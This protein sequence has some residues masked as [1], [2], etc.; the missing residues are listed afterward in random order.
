MKTSVTFLICSGIAGVLL[1]IG[2]LQAAAANTGNADRNIKK[3]MIKQE[4][5]NMAEPINR[6]KTCTPESLGISS[7]AL[8]KLI[9]AWNTYEH[10]H[11]FIIK[12]NGRTAAE[13]F[14][15]PYDL[16][17]PHMLFSLS[18]SFISCAVGFAIEEKRFS[19]DTLIL[20]IFPEYKKAVTDERFNRMTIRHLL[21][22]STGHNN[23]A[24]RYFNRQTDP[25]DFK[26]DFFASPLRFEP[27]T[28]FVYNSAATYIL[29]AAVRKVT[30]E[31]P[32]V[33]LRKRLLDPLG[34]GER[35]W[36]KSPDGTDCGGWGY[37]LTTR[38]ISSFAEMLRNGGRI[39]GRQVIPADYFASAVSKLAD[40]SKNDAPDWK[41]G[42]GF[43][44]WRTRHNAFRADGSFGQYAIVM[45]D[46]DMTIAITSG[47]S[48]MPGI[49]D[50]L[51]DNLLPGV[52]DK[53]LPENPQAYAELQQKIAK[54][55]LPVLK[56][57]APESTH[58]ITASF[59]GAPGGITGLEITVS[60]ENCRLD[61]RRKDRPQ[62][63]ITAGWGQPVRG[64]TDIE[65][66]HPDP[67]S[68]TAEISSG[69]LKV[70]VYNCGAP[71]YSDYIFT[72]KDGVLSLDRQRNLVYRDRNWKIFSG[73]AVSDISS[74][75]EIR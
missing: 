32:S 65:D 23:C 5:C 9:D 4:T 44:F 1:P 26:R 43:Q 10:V 70:R 58:K 40:T 49:L 29:S 17:T 47:G 59:T 37:C 66:D 54:L 6:K 62:T 46:L 35:Y 68:A 34:I 21:T 11:S 38:E 51:W 33:Y 8:I 55:S 12:R 24:L 19:L 75:A 39:N 31:N 7:T 63:A 16:D 42:Y 52:S 25:I 71:F 60:P 18:K 20:D 74:F 27:G 30:G 22:M 41:L 67:V 2:N 72:L 64:T 14:W 36:E 28:R 13:G 53:P 69:T 56:G 73:K 57:K 45:P 3:A 48:D 61:F 15:K 50:I